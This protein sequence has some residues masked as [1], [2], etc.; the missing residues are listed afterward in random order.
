MKIKKPTYRF[1]SVLLVDDNELDNFINQKMM[2]ANH[3]A[4]I[5]YTA[6]NG[7]SAMDF[8]KNLLL[9]DK[10]T[11][12]EVI[13]VDLNMPLMDGFQFIEYFKSDTALRKKEVKLVILT[14]SVNAHDRTRA[15]TYGSDIV[16]L[17]KPLNP[18]MLETVI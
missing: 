3:I 8:I 6:T 11:F 10:A 9:M 16:F 4:Q 12:P 15:A 13:F 18:K 17:N 5:I 1:R 2:E 14:S 7:R